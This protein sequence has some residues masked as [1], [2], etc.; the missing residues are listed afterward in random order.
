VVC[1]TLLLTGLSCKNPFSPAIDYAPVSGGGAIGD[2]KNVE[3]IFTNMQIAYTT[4]DTLIYGKLLDD[5]FLFTYRD[6]DLGYDVTWGRQEE[7]KVTASMFQNSESLSLIWNNVLV[8]SVEDTVALYDRAFNLVIVFNPSDVAR[9]DGRVNLQL[10]KTAPNG[11][12]KISRWI[13][14]SNF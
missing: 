7:M 11:I 3:D 12:W 8:S 4:K 5:G 1:G 13:D 6:Y 10:V 2:Q 9:V 14:E